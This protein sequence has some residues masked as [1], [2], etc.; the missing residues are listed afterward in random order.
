MGYL[1]NSWLASCYSSTSS[2]WALSACRHSIVFGTVLSSSL[3]ACPH[4]RRKVRLSHKS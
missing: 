2:T 1:I 3:M 4:C